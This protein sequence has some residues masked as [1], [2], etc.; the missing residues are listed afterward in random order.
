MYGFTQEQI[1]GKK[2]RKEIREISEDPVLRYQVTLLLDQL[3][4]EE[5]AVESL[6]G[7][8]PEAGAPFMREI[9]I[10]TGMKGISVFIAIAIIADIA[11]IIGV[12]T[13]P[14]LVDTV[15]RLVLS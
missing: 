7:R 8:I 6:K 3:E 10:L 1:F 5:E 13:L 14:R 12:W 4:R 2:S 11:D 9:N 15:K